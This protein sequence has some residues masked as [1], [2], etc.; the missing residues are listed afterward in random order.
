MEAG[1]VKDGINNFHISM[2]EPH[3]ITKGKVS[4]IMH[5]VGTLTMS[6]QFGVTQ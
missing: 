4:M 1:L 3:K 5:F 2:T 6:E